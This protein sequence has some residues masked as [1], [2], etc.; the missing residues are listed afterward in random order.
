MRG[1]GSRIHGIAV[2]AELYFLR[3]AVTRTLRRAFDLAFSA[4]FAAAVAGAV[5]RAHSR[6]YSD[7]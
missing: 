1:S 6:A 7:G 5:P 4:I 3:A 2:R